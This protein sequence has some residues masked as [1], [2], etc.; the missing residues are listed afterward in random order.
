MKILLQKIVLVC[1]VLASVALPIR[2]EITNINGIVFR[3]NEYSVDSRTSLCIPGSEQLMWDGDKLTIEFDLKVSRHGDHFGYVCSI[4]T[5][6]GEIVSLFLTNPKNSSPYL[7]TVDD[8]GRLRPIRSESEPIDIYEWNRISL[9]LVAK[10]DSIVV[11]ENGQAMFTKKRAPGRV[12]LKVIFGMGHLSGKSCIDVAPMEIRDIRLSLS[13]DEVYDFPLDRVESDS[14]VYDKDN[15]L[16]ARLKNHE[17]I[18]DKH[19]RWKLVRSISLAQKAYSVAASGSP[20]LYLVS[21]DRIIKVDLVKQRVSEV[22]YQGESL[23]MNLLS[24]NFIVI[25]PRRA[26]SLVYYSID[27]TDDQVADISRFDFGTA[28]WT[29]SINPKRQSNYINHSRYIT[30]HDSVVVQM[31]GYGFHAYKNDFSRINIADGLVTADKKVLKGVSPRYLS[32]TGRVDDSHVIVF[33]GIGNIYGDQEFGTKVFNDLYMLDTAADTLT[34]ML[35]NNDSRDSGIAVD[36]LLYNVENN[37]VMGLFFEPFK[38]NT[39]LTLKELD[40]ETGIMKTLSDSIPYRFSDV[41]SS[42]RLFYLPQTDMLYAVTVSCNSGDNG[43]TTD[44]YTLQLPLLPYT[45][46]TP[47]A[48]RGVCSSAWLWISV[49]IIVIAVILL[50]WY[51][52]RGNQAGVVK[53]VPYQSVQ[54][55]E[56]E[57]VSDPT[58]VPVPAIED[59]GEIAGDDVDTIVRP[60]AP[61][62]PG[63]TF[64]GGFK[65][66]NCRGENITGSFTPILRQILILVV[67]YT[68]KNGEGV[69]NALLK[70]CLWFDKSDESFLNNRS[71]NMRKLRVLLPEI[72]EFKLGSSHGNWRLETDDC[73]IV[74]YFAAMAVIKSIKEKGCGSDYRRVSR[75]LKYSSRGP[76][77]PECQFE[78]L[79]AFKGA[80]SDLMIQTLHSVLDE[81]LV[82]ANPELALGVANSILM[83][84]SIDEDAVKTKCRI[85]LRANR[86]GSAAKAFDRFVKEYYSLMNESFSLSFNEFVG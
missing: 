72:G 39:S 76:L 37:T 19:S 64:L 56:S 45:A 31:F 69:S 23:D 21:A 42:A 79:D 66:V 25:G 60:D 20:N 13:D 77:L 55:P 61:L 78:W 6:S 85:L 41:N 18:I 27:D 58:P 67:L 5:G 65:V 29:P 28:V 80:Y 63:V 9:E 84:D 15:R 26:E 81:N 30:N 10:G 47:G 38:A 68:E 73:Q 44:I 35:S 43:Y 51:L 22:K 86:M 53:V 50:L 40:V 2:S 71:V 83:F 8:G 75:L 70:D 12:S 49:A 62:L 46:Y 32:A 57:P 59:V 52:K 34:C 54:Q 74:D 17:W 11:Y 7:C 36:E 33:G 4:G 16:A 24:N 82:S 48:A 1:A 14:V 3:G